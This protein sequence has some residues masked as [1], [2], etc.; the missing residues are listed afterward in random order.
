MRR[1]VKTQDVARRWKRSERV[2]VI[3]SRPSAAKK[4]K[5]ERSEAS[6]PSYP[7]P[8]QVG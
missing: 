7:R 6:R 2:E 3:M 1:V 5:P 8:C 4:G